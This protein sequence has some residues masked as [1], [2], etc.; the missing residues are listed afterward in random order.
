MLGVALVFMPV[1]VAYQSWVYRR[2][3]FEISAE[4]IEKGN[5]Y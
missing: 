2:F 3:S 1:V 5:A 4:D